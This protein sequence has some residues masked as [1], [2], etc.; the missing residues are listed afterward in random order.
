MEMTPLQTAF[1][2]FACTLSGAQLG[3]RLR[4]LLPVEHLSDDAKD[5]VKL[6]TGFVASMAA[7]VIGLM[8]SSSKGSFDERSAELSSVATDIIMLDR[9][10]ADYGL[11]TKIARTS[12]REMTKKWHH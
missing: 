3:P 11:E 12:L 9:T 6:G 1:V 10:L 4:G 7:L 2:V 5:V 8:V